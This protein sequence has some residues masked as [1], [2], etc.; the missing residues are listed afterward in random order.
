MTE[1]ELTRDPRRKAPSIAA[2][3]SSAR[4]ASRSFCRARGHVLK[5][6]ADV[7]DALATEVCAIFDGTPAATDPSEPPPAL[8]AFRKACDGNKPNAY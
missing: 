7:P 1:L 2:V 5:I 6:G 4:T 8:A 3:A